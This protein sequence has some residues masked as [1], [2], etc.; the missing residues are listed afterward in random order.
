MSMPATCTAGPLIPAPAGLADPRLVAWRDVVALACVDV[1]RRYQAAWSQSLLDEAGRAAAAVG[2]VEPRPDLD[3]LLLPEQG[4]LARLARLTGIDAADEAVLATT[5]WAAVDPQVAAL[6]GCVHDDAARRHATLGLL[7]QVLAPLGLHVPLLLGEHHA[8]V[9]SGLMEPVPDPATPLRLPSTTVAVLA[10][11]KRPA[12]SP[13]VV[14][15]RLATLAEQVRAFLATGARVLVRCAVADD[16]SVLRDAVANLMGTA[17]APVPRL[18]AVAALLLELGHELPAVLLDDDAPPEGTVLALGGPASTV[19]SGWHIVDAEP[20]SLEAATQVWRVALRRSG[21]RPAEPVLVDL[22]GRLP[23]AEHTIAGIVRMAASSAT[24]LGRPPLLADV[25]AALRAYPRHDTGGLA[26]RLQA[27]GSLDD[28]VLPA[29][30]R[31]ALA[32]F[33]AHARWSP[34]AHVSL[35]LSGAR[36]RAV[37]ALFQGPSGTGKTAAAE[38]TAAALD[39]DLWIV[40]LAKVVS[41][42]LGETQRHLDTVLSQASM[43]GALLLFDEADGLFGKRG[44]VTD[45]RDRYANLEIDHL[46]Q[47]IELHEGVVVLTSNRPGALDDAFARRIRLAVRFDLPDHES[48]EEIWARYLPDAL[49]DEGVS[50]ADVAREELSGAGIRAAALAATVSAIDAGTPVRE[51]HLATAVRRELEKSRRP[52]TARPDRRT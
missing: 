49:L 8:L 10:G 48:R 23:L 13:C 4:E 30:T 9:T 25:S 7:A 31:A 6:L 50:R 45:A 41:K 24:A 19:P 32:D 11:D 29:T 1:L 28:L 12:P 2:V 14:G 35:G 52:P 27:S 40:D 42:W 17:V 20:P 51:E 18:P 43:A 46:L 44:E 39:R 36:G 33:M 16:R 15:G 37:I 26:R 38:A 47:R 21:L 3:L 22:A 5:W 34:A